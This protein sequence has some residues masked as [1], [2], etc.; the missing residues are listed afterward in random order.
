MIRTVRLDY[1]C[2]INFE[3]MISRYV[4]LPPSVCKT[5]ASSPHRKLPILSKIFL[6][7]LHPGGALRPIYGVQPIYFTEWSK[8]GVY[9]D[10]HHVITSWQ[11]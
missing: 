11:L 5:I 10:I 1:E 8:H 9:R 3:T 4:M 7:E 2:V 6:I